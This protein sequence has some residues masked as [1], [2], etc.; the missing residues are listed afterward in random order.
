MWKDV[1]TVNLFCGT[2]EPQIAAFSWE[3][4]RHEWLDQGHHSALTLKLSQETGIQTFVLGWSRL[5]SP[6]QNYNRCV[7]K[8]SCYLLKVRQSVNPNKMKPCSFT[9][10]YSNF[11]VPSSLQKS[12]L[13]PHERTNRMRRSTNNRLARDRL[14][15]W[16]AKMHIA[17]SRW[18]WSPSTSLKPLIAS[19]R[20]QNFQKKR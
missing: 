4:Y 3:I 16:V 17:S 1:F 11:A 9:E 18:Y 5:K 8:A 14:R 13:K 20:K 7:W 15:N 6:D 19:L 10:L 12:M 2:I